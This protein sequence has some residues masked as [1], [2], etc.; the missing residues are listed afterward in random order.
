[1]HLAP[2]SRQG[3]QCLSCHSFMLAQCMLVTHLLVAVECVDNKAQQLIDL[4]LQTATSLRTQQL[5]V[6][7]SDLGLPLAGT[8]VRC[9]WKA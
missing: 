3:N 8:D 7:N 4:G 9:T 1:M 2:N 6:V 5:R